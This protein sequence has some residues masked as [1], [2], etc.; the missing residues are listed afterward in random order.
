MRDDMFSRLNLMFLTIAK[1]A[2]MLLREFHALGFVHRDIKPA[3]MTILLKPAFQ[4]YI[5]DFGLSQMYLSDRVQITPH[6]M[7]F[8][9]T[10]MF[11]P[12]AAHEKIPQTPRDDIES[13]C[14]TL[15]YINHQLPW[16]GFPMG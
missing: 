13:L 4:V 11:A 12:R 16:R 10:L 5:I 7:G 8:V 9:G 6:R 1:R 15:L 14:Y 2:I 3:N